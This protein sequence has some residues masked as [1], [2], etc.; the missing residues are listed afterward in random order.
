MRTLSTALVILGVIMLLL[1]F[2]ASIV[3]ARGDNIG[4][5]YLDAA[6]AGLGV[7]VG[8]IALKPR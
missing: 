5:L 2:V 3:D 1:I 6:L 4:I 7:I 8:G